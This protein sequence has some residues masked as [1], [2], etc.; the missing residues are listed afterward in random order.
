VLVAVVKT[1]LTFLSQ[2]GPA[3]GASDTQPGVVVEDVEDLD[4]RTVGEAVVGDVELPAF[5]GGVGDKPPPTAAGAFMRLWGDESAGG[6]DPP[7]RRHGR[8]GVRAVT[9][10]QVCDDGRGASLMPAAVEVFA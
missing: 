8:H 5:V 2:E 9:L 3:G 6:Q 4:L 7:D 1:V 10:L